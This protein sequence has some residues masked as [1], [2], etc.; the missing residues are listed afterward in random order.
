MA[1]IGSSWSHTVRSWRA[2][3]G[4]DRSL[5]E[6][7]IRC[8]VNCNNWAS[9]WYPQPHVYPL[10]YSF[11]RIP[12]HLLTRLFNSITYYYLVFHFCKEPNWNPLHSL[13]SEIL[14]L[15]E[16]LCFVTH[17]LLFTIVYR[18]EVHETYYD[19]LVPFSIF[20]FFLFSP[21]S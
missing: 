19:T 1:S 6:T 7:W 17:I 8:Q 15:Y 16:L 12:V 5:Q 18:S 13:V 4:F 2:N 9:H 14:Q 20:F 3:Q 21:W 10:S 11:L